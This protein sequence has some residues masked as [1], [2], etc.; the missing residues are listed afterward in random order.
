M[1]VAET[2]EKEAQAEYEKMMSDSADKRAADSASVSTKAEAKA[3]TEA[4]LQAHKDD[5][6]SATN[7]L[8]STLETIKAHHSE[9]DWLIEYYSV[10][11]EARAS[12]IDSLGNAKAVLS[13]S[14]YSL[15]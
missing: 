14:D 7:E 12:E 6:A 15:L 8:M 10:R 9:C 3:S 1:T 5:K 11:K 4:S 2:D 13:G